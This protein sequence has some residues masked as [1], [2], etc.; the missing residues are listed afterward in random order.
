MPEQIAPLNVSFVLEL[1]GFDLLLQSLRQHGYRIIGPRLRDGAIVYDEL[2]A[3]SDLPIGWTDEQEGGTYRLKKRNDKTL[4]GFAVGPHSWKQFFHPPAVRLWQATR[5]AKGFKFQPETLPP[6]KLALL[7]VRSCE[8]HA[9]AIQDNVFLNGDN[10][11]SAYQSRREN[12]FVMAV[13]CGQAGGT[14][15]CVSMK[16]GPR[17]TAG[18]DLVLTEVC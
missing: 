18:Y 12:T 10:V 9:I 3:A 13:N 14:C 7:G 5:D 15:F 2:T 8:L 11:D 16:T 17:A 4:F 6:P 1:T